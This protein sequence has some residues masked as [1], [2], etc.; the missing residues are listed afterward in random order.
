[1]SDNTPPKPESF[2]KSQNEPMD[3]DEFT[4]EKTKVDEDSAKERLGRDIYTDETQAFE[5][6]HSNGVTAIHEAAERDFIDFSDGVFEIDL[7]KDEDGNVCMRVRDNGIGMN[8]DIVRDVF[9][10][11]GITT[12]AQNENV[13]AQFGMGVAS[14]PNLVGFH[15]G[16]IYME[17]NPRYADEAIYGYYDIDGLQYKV[18]TDGLRLLGEEEYGTAYEMWL[19]D[20]ISAN[21]V[22]SW[23][24][25]VSDYNDVPIK[26]NY[27]TGD[28]EVIEPSTIYD[29]FESDNSLFIEFEDEEIGK[30]VAG[31]N[32]PDD[33]VLIH[34]K[35]E[36]NLNTDNSPPFKSN[37][38]IRLYTESE[39]VCEGEHKGKIVMDDPKYESLDEETK[40]RHIRRS[41]VPDDVAVTPRVV[42]NREKLSADDRFSHWVVENL[43]QTHYDRVERCVSS[44]E[45]VDD[46]YDMGRKDANYV[47][48]AL[49]N[50]VFKYSYKY[51]NFQTKMDERYP[52]AHVETV[53]DNNTSEDYSISDNTA[54]ILSALFDTADIMEVDGTGSSANIGW[55]IERVRRSKDTKVYMGVSIN[56]KKKR[57]ARDDDPNSIIVRV[58]NADVYDR[59]EPVFGWNK[60][61]EIKK[62]TLDEYDISDETKNLFK[63]KTKSVSGESNSPAETLTVH[64]GRRKHSKKK[65]TASFIKESLEDDNADALH[66]TPL[67][68]FPESASRYLSDYYSFAK[69]D[70]GLFNCNNST[71]E[72]LKQFD[73]VK[74]ING[75]LQEHKSITEVS[76]E[77]EDTEVQMALESDDYYVIVAPKQKLEQYRNIF[78]DQELCNRFKKVLENEKLCRGR[79]LD[80]AMWNKEVMVISDTKLRD[81]HFIF[82]N[83]NTTN[84]FDIND[85][86]LYSSVVSVSELTRSEFIEIVAHLMLID[87]VDE[88]I[89]NEITSTITYYHNPRTVLSNIRVALENGELQGAPD[90]EELDYNI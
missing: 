89:Y 51:Q 18:D 7:M 38:F 53:I 77:G 35:I 88:D 90:M 1:M 37:V 14:Y 85:T 29:K 27:E 72:S 31:M 24:E 50:N 23:V 8:E 68:A 60:L 9:L 79:Y 62:S 40:E 78:G 65:M 12:G 67:V 41:E 55:K 47:Q 82:D 34:R 71:W 59:Y 45:S 76:T 19:R 33:T 6:M 36:F 83:I 43:R 16:K 39:K 13:V 15:D 56:D 5:E 10:N 63:T 81:N 75:I 80:S 58:D 66:G 64:Y 84:I 86:T 2:G 28:T 69:R 3:S 87:W 26:L 11:F 4:Y 25:R 30:F 20:D 57:V 73:E 22:K 21:D 49:S 17:T 52:P 54:N 42:G 70:A 32:V 61:K 74:H 44:I 46:F 48:L